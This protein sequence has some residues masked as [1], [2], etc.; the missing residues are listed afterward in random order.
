MIYRKIPVT[1]GKNFRLKRLT[2]I[3]MSLGD[4][5]F[6]LARFS[7]QLLAETIPAPP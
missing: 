1:P 3:D 5:D 7:D 2:M 6:H 4:V